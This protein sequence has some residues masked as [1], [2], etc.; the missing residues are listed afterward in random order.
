MFG[1]SKEFLYWKNETTLDGNSI[2]TFPAGSGVADCRLYRGGGN[3][4]QNRQSERGIHHNP[5]LA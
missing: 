1:V 4:R 5:T 3:D 2:P